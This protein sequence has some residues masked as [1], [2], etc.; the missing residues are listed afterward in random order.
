MLHIP[1]FYQFV[2]EVVKLKSAWRCAKG[3]NWIKF[4]AFLPHQSE[5]FDCDQSAKLRKKRTNLQYGYKENCSIKKV[6][7][8]ETQKNLGEWTERVPETKR[9]IKMNWNMDV[10][11]GRGETPSTGKMSKVI[12]DE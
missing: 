4:K 3:D 5:C 7:A 6:K 10:S 11:L 9:K 12:V 1:I 2:Q 8:F